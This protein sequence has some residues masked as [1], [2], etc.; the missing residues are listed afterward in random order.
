[1]AYIKPHDEVK[2]VV[3][4]GEPMLGAYREKSMLLDKAKIR[5]TT[6]NYFRKVTK[7]VAEGE[8]LKIVSE[9]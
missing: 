6:H 7:V 4:E 1:M 9:F 3:I 5:K 8:S 2:N